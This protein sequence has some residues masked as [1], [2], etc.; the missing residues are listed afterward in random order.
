MTIQKYFERNKRVLND[1]I[2]RKYLGETE[3]N[4]KVIV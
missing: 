1:V 2:F 3:E 4:S